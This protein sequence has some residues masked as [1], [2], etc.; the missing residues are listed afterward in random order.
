M[1]GST[2]K[3]RLLA[4]IESKNISIRKFESEAELGNA[5]VEGVGKSLRQTS[6]DKIKAKYP[7]FDENWIVT[8]IRSGSDTDYRALY[9]DLQRAVNEYFN[10]RDAL[11]KLSKHHQSPPGSDEIFDGGSALDK[12]IVYSAPKKDKKGNGGK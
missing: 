1:K 7:D 4:Y 8:G 10:S 12:E 5:F 9:E 3:D 2:P 6:V 11:Q